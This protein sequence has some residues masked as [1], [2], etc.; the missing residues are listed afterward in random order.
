M[1]IRNIIL[2]IIFFLEQKSESIR[3][4]FNFVRK[5]FIPW[6]EKKKRNVEKYSHL[7]SLSS[8]FSHFHIGNDVIPKKKKRRKKKNFGTFPIRPT[9][10][11]HIFYVDAVTKSAMFFFAATSL[12]VVAEVCYFT[13]HV[14]H[15]RHRLCVFVAGVVFIVSGE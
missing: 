12:L 8:V 2:Q 15:P 9:F 3:I 6:T 4:N 10:H 11:T 14:T 5:F 13:A 1:T 7:K